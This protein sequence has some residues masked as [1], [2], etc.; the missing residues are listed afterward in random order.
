MKNSIQR[1]AAIVM[2]AVVLSLSACQGKAQEE[3]QV[4]DWCMEDLSFYDY[5]RSPVMTLGKPKK[6]ITITQRDLQTYRGVMVRDDAK[7]ALQKYNMEEFRFAFTQGFQ[8]NEIGKKALAL[9]KK[10]ED[11]SAV[12][13]LEHIDEVPDFGGDFIYGTWIIL[14]EG[15]L[16]AQPHIEKYDVNKYDYIFMFRFFI[17]KG[18]I[19]EIELIY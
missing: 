11:L 19:Y 2:M 6:K 15:N 14:D 7:E 13:M 12:E 9:E 1:R 16:W 17:K 8:G 18:R 5:T 3:D 4:Q 10:Y